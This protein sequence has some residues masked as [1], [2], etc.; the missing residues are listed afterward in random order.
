M[1]EPTKNLQNALRLVETLPHVQHHARTNEEFTKRLRGGPR[2]SSPVSLQIG[3]GK[4]RRKGDNVT[5]RLE[6]L[7]YNTPDTWY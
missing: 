5:F 2:F 6:Q 3:L 7:T 4:Q 1:W